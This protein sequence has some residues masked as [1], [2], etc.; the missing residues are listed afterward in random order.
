MGREQLK[1]EQ[2]SYDAFE[3]VNYPYV[4]EVNEDEVKYHWK[5]TSHSELSIN[6]NLCTD[7]F[8]MKLY[9]GTKP[10]VFDC[11]KDLYKGIIIESFGNGGL[12]LKEGTCFRKFKS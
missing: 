6:T 10:E 9:P 7:V 3:S 12:P 1:C 5:P 2:K 8:L 11:L 4:A